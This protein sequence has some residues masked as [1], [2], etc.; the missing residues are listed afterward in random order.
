MKNPS[1]NINSLGLDGKN[2]NLISIEKLSNEMDNI[3]YNQQN[4]NINS[5]ININNYQ[6][7]NLFPNDLLKSQNEELNLSN[8]NIDQTQKFVQ[9][10]DFLFPE[11]ESVNQN[12]DSNKNI[13]LNINNLNEKDISKDDVSQSISEDKR[14]EYVNNLFG[15]S[16]SFSMKS[17]ASNDLSQSLVSEKRKELA[18]ELFRTISNSSSKKKSLNETLKTNKTNISFAVN[19]LSGSNMGLNINELANKYADKDKIICEVEGQPSMASGSGRRNEENNS[20]KK[21]IKNNIKKSI[22]ESIKES[23]NEY[24]KDIDEDD[25]ISFKN[26]LIEFKNKS[27]IDI[28]V[29]NLKNIT[30]FNSNIKKDNNLIRNSNKNDLVSNSKEINVNINNNNNNISMIDNENNNKNNIEKEKNIKNDNNNINN[31]NS[32]INLSNIDFENLPKFNNDKNNNKNIILKN[33]INVENYNKN[34]NMLKKPNFAELFKKSKNKN[35]LK[36]TEEK[37]RGMID[38]E[39]SDD[40][41][42]NDILNKKLRLTDENNESSIFNNN[43]IPS[44][45]SIDEDHSIIKDKNDDK[46]KKIELKKENNLPINNEEEK[47]MESKYKFKQIKKKEI[48]NVKRSQ[49]NLSEE[50]ENEDN[51]FDNE[52]KD[53]IYFDDKGLSKEKKFKSFLNENRL[54]FNENIHDKEENNVQ[55]KGIK[56]NNYFENYICKQ[57]TVIDYINKKKKKIEIPFYYDNI[58]KTYEENKNNFNTLFQFVTEVDKKKLYESYKK[59]EFLNISDYKISPYINSIDENIKGKID[60]IRYTIDE[61]YGDTFYRCFMFNLIENYILNKEKENLCILIFD[62]F[63]LYDLAPSIY[64]NIRSSD[65]KSTLIFFSFLYDYI[66]LNMWEKVYFLYISIYQKLEQV[67]I[68]YIRYSIFLFLS[69]LYNENINNNKYLYQYQKVLV[70]YN[71]PTHLIFQIIPF[72][73]GLNLEIINFKNKEENQMETQNFVFNPPKIINKNSINT[74]YIIFQYNCYHIGYQKSIF[75]NNKDILKFIKE[76]LNK[77]SLFHYT[78]NGEIICEKCNKNTEYIEINKDNNKG[79]C[80]ECLN[81]KIDEYLVKRISFINQDY[82]KYYINY[83][84]YL[85]PIELIL[86]KPDNSIV[87]TNLDYYSLNYKTFEQRISELFPSS[88]ESNNQINNINFSFDNDNDNNVCLICQKNNNIVTSECGCKFCEDCLYEIFLSITNNKVILNGYEKSQLSNNNNDKC[89]LCEKNLNLHYLIMLFEEKGKNFEFEYNEAKIRMKNCCK[90]MCFDCLKKFSNEKSLEVSHNSQKLM[91]QIKVMIN[92]HCF[93]DSKRN[94]G[95]AIE[96]E[97]EIDYSDVD[98]I[99]CLECFKRNRNK[100]IKRINDVEYKVIFC[101]IC[102]IKHYSNMK[103]WDKWDRNDICCKCHI[104]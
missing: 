35:N 103:E 92:K 43:K 58:K 77:T 98:H 54:Y 63:K 102:G 13:N 34:N 45:I 24:D 60:Y 11:E 66:N 32:E 37:K 68:S 47:H 67:L 41:V 61:N 38:K 79:I 44:R 94:I 29:S 48:D 9:N 88:V 15:N 78:Q 85:R 71:E 3:N 26:N 70:N 84:Y 14:I 90:T 6:N 95:D 65:I 83:S 19:N 56:E 64:N 86:K 10:A 30:K 72:I 81:S 62:I 16:I 104:F 33:K 97:Y 27:Q 25:K 69:Q 91:L 12:N 51:S 50:N 100:K 93:K 55:L 80:L 59:N 39:N 8:I 21:S 4:N 1:R 87:I 20:R 52:K 49:R 2:E 99:V 76:N 57:E 46:N 96:E 75:D 31:S 36:I 17:K 89:P 5:N 101:N 42:S 53:L 7:N 18:D 82:K 40:E 28:K 74:I 22:K 73:F 23:M